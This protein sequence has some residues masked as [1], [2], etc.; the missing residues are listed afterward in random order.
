MPVERTLR[1]QYFKI[2]DWYH[3]NET[4]YGHI[5]AVPINI[6]R[7]E[8]SSD[9][10]VPGWQIRFDRKDEKYKSCFFSDSAY[11]GTAQALTSATN[12]LFRLV[13]DYNY[14][15]TDELCAIRDLENTNKGIKCGMPG[16]SISVNLNF[17]SPR[18]DI[19]VSL[20][21]KKATFAKHLL[22][23]QIFKL[24]E[25]KFSQAVRNAIQLRLFWM[26]AVENDVQVSDKQSAT[27]LEKFPTDGYTIPSLLETLQYFYDA[28]IPTPTFSSDTVRFSKTE[29][30]GEIVYEVSRS[31]QIPGYNLERKIF[32]S[33]VIGS[34][35]T[36]EFLAVL[37]ANTLQ[38]RKPVLNS[39]KAGG[40]AKV[41]KTVSRSDSVHDTTGVFGVEF[42]KIDLE[43]HFIVRSSRTK[44]IIDNN[45]SLM[46]SIEEF[47]FDAAFRLAAINVRRKHKLPIDDQTIN[48][49]LSTA[50]QTIRQANPKLYLG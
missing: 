31:V 13:D 10:S 45:N 1:S 39:G 3:R 5:Y 41:K 42:G 4:V 16:V 12:E 20:V 21:S 17:F 50:R 48:S 38:N 44:E 28:T 35:Y 27:I 22:N 7:V 43:Y 36:A 37:Y 6:N 49:E 46:F 15:H 11:G 34:S 29:Q 14:R 47:G 8:P 18:I 32:N 19:Q 2:N 23:W 25:S 40:Q 24:T 30:I 9:D 26:N 33:K